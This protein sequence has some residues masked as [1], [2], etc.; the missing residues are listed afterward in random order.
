M[1]RVRLWMC[2]PALQY[3]IQAIRLLGAREDRLVNI[4]YVTA[5]ASIC[6]STLFLANPLEL[7]NKTLHIL[8]PSSLNFGKLG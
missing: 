2:F 8:S 1:S 4:S 5:H 6:I 3:G 7:C